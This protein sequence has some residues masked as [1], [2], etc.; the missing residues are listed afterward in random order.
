MAKY[1]NEIDTR[2]SS[3]YSFLNIVT[4]ICVIIFV[5]SMVSSIITYSSLVDLDKKLGAQSIDS[6]TSLWI[7]IISN[8]IFLAGVLGL[9]YIFKTIIEL[10]VLLQDETTEIYDTIY[11]ETQNIKLQTQMNPKRLSK[12]QVDA[13]E[14]LASVTEQRAK[15]RELLRLEE[16]RERKL[17]EEAERKFKE[18][19][20]RKF[21]ENVTKL[22][23]ESEKLKALEKINLDEQPE[24]E[25]GKIA[26]EQAS[27]K[28]KRERDLAKLA[29]EA[30]QRRQAQKN[31]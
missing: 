16:E 21:K 9:R 29:W 7:P 15:E 13:S 22:K 25:R 5:V 26:Q 1:R 18:E 23:E 19:T 17:K 3:L 4:I 30:E 24:D 12:K 20:K 31:K 28:E 6:W 11:K 2:I 14:R 8:V 10:F 27:L